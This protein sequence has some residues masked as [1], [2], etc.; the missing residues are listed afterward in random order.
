MHKVHIQ[1]VHAHFMQ[2]SKRVAALSSSSLF[3]KV[4]RALFLL[5]R[6]IVFKTELLQAKETSISVAIN[7]HDL[8][9]SAVL[10]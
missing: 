4:C 9:H 1:T 8:P 6:L 5:Q 10:D 2:M 7:R 3:A